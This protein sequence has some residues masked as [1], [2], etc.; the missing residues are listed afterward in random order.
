[1]VR[2]PK[3]PDSHMSGFGAF[4]GGTKS[5]H[6]RMWCLERHRILA[7]QDPVPSKCASLRC[8]PLFEYYRSPSEGVRFGPL[9]EGFSLELGHYNDNRH[10]Y[11]QLKFK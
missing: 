10:G 7:C 11:L 4:W 3:A 1:M 8:P 6:V 9:K 5:S 2:V